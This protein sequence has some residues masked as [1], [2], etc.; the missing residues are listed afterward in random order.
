M[1]A[2]FARRNTRI[3]AV[4]ICIAETTTLPSY[5]LLWRRVA[6]CWR[7]EKVMYIVSAY[8][9]IT[10]CCRERFSSRY[11]STV[12]WLIV[13]H[14]V[15]GEMR[16]ATLY[17][18]SVKGRVLLQCTGGGGG[19]EENVA[20]VCCVLRDAMAYVGVSVRVFNRDFTNRGDIVRETAN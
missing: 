4:W 20:L 14:C 16:L 17:C 19:G 13:L 18:C 9:C 15:S 3:A 12:V 2:T 6:K 10:E 1:L 7:K 5:L 8:Y 11:C